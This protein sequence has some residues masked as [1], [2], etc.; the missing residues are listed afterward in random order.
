MLKKIFSKK[1][2]KENP[3]N[4]HQDV[5]LRLMFEIALSDGYLD[6]SE[7][8]L[9]KIRAS[10]LIDGD[11]KVST[12]IKKVI[13]E[14]QESTSIYPTVKKIN[15]KYSIEEKKQLLEILWSV[16]AADKMINHHEEALYFKIAELIKIKR[17]AANKIKQEYS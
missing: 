9:I 14:T 4:K 11:Q 6:K 8:E 3:K 5:A 1:S 2:E 15:D 10:K 17:P 16:V 12:I 13:D 7:L